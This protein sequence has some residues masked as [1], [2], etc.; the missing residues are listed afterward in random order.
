VAGDKATVVALEGTSRPL[1][2][3][4]EDPS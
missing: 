3:R 2:R 4:P 1:A